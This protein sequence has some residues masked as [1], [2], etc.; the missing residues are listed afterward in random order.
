[1]KLSNQERQIAINAF[2]ETNEEERLVFIDCNC[3]V[4]AEDSRY[5]VACVYAKHYE[6]EYDYIKAIEDECNGIEDA[7]NDYCN[8]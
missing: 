8:S 3:Y 1:M 7:V 4:L 2:N 5:T 6:D